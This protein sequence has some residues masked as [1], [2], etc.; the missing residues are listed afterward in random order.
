M[1][2]KPLL[3][4]IESEAA[5]WC[6]TRDIFFYAYVGHVENGFCTITKFVNKVPTAGQKLF[7]VNNIKYTL[8]QLYSQVYAQSINQ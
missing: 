8:T 1:S 5:S 3:I 2:V 7:P 4:T 6:Y